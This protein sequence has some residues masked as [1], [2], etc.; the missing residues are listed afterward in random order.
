MG[1]RG[2]IPGGQR[3]LLALGLGLVVIASLVATGAAAAGAATQDSNGNVSE[4]A[5]VEPAPEPGDPY[6]EAAATDGSWVSYENPRDEYP[7]SVSR[8]RLREGLRYAGQRKR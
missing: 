4:E 1:S 7:Q 5:Y 6:F 8:R 2:S 3:G